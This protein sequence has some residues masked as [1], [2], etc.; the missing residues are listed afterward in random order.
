MFSSV[1]ATQQCSQQ[2][3]GDHGVVILYFFLS[4]K[5]DRLLGESGWGRGGW[6]GVGG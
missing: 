2:P 3:L 1:S 4:Y 6:A 5:P